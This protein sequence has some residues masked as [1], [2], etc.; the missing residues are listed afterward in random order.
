M[1]P[2]V[3]LARAADV[4]DPLCPFPEALAAWIDQGL[5]AADRAW[6]DA[7]LVGCSDCRSLVAQVIEIQIE[8]GAHAGPQAELTARPTVRPTLSGLEWVSRLLLQRRSRWWSWPVLGTGR[9]AAV[10]RRLGTRGSCAGSGSGCAQSKLARRGFVVVRCER[11]CVPG[12]ARCQDGR[13]GALGCRRQDPRDV[14][15]RDRVRLYR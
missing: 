3:R 7:H 12:G 6:I 15:T 4:A 5:G 14:K 13:S 9:T 8:A 10:D 1:D 11:R 2:V